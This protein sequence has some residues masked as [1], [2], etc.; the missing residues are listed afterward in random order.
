MPDPG[1]IDKLAGRSIVLVGIMGSGKSSVG[2]RLAARLGL[3]FID[4]DKEIEAAAGMTI[5]EIFAQHGEPYFR[6]GERRVID[7]LLQNRQVVL[8]TG[9]GAYMN[10]QTRSAITRSGISVWLKADHDVLMRRVRKRSNRPLLQAPDPDK[11]MQD[12]MDERYPVYAMADVTVVSGDGPHEKVVEDVVLAVSSYLDG[13]VDQVRA[14]TKTVHVDVADRSYDVV[15]GRQ[16]IS[17]AASFI[18]R[19]APQASCAI[20]TDENVG[21]HH[22]TALEASLDAAGIRNQHF[23]LPPG[24]RSKSIGVYSELCDSILAARFERRDLL[25]ALGGGVIGDLTGFAAACLRRGMRF[26]QIPTT[27]L[28]QVDSSVGGKTAINSAHGKNLIGAFHQPSLVLADVSALASLPDREFRAGYAEVVK[29]GLINDEALFHWLENNCS[30]IF[31]HEPELIEAVRASCAAKA[32][33]VAR[34]ETEQ[35][36]RALLNL[37]HTFGHALEALTGYDSDILVHGEGVAIGLACAA[38]FSVKLGY[39][40]GQDALRI[41]HHLQNCGLPVR[42]AEVRTHEPITPESVLGAMYQDK[43]IIN[44]ELTFIL[45]RGIGQSF[46]ARGIKEQQVTEFLRDELKAG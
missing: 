7:R 37:G 9:G 13:P 45:M 25:I 5:P 33:I 30:R 15:I 3:E 36:E 11:V 20:V 39:M 4:A 16:L 44:G 6:S 17:N 35:G 43:K 27:L 42:L 19:I 28:A 1:L 38:R 23:I 46:I 29:Y 24:E 32:R 21:L 2:R 34:D 12:L 31:A 26:V 18:A 40:R 10:E 14:E 41:E 8:A 22:L